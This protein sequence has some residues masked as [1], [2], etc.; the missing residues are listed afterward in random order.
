MFTEFNTRPSKIQMSRFISFPLVHITRLEQ[1]G[2][3]S[4]R[5]SMSI[6]IYRLACTQN[7]LWVREIYEFIHFISTPKFIF[8]LVLNKVGQSLV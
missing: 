5:I 6:H 8:I 7:D 1:T 2:E 3:Y 4:I